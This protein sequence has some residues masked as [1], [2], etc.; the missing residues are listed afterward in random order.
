VR[1]AIQHFFLLRTNVAHPQLSTDFIQIANA[2]VDAE[3]VS[4][5]L[6]EQAA[7]GV[8]SRLSIADHPLADRFPDLVD[9]AMPLIVQSRFPFHLYAPLPSIGGCTA[10]RQTHAG[11]S[12]AASTVPGS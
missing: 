2:Q 9:M 12:F 10:D 11:N 3:L 6:L 8:W 1:F 7:W 4:Q 5:D